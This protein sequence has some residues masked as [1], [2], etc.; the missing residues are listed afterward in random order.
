MYSPSQFHTHSRYQANR[1]GTE[2]RALIHPVTGLP[3]LRTDS[4]SEPSIS[5]RVRLDIAPELDCIQ[6]CARDSDRLMSGLPVR[7]VKH[8]VNKN[9]QSAS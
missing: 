8:L 4:T 7:K 6:P 9:R 1:L 2:P 3:L 5:H